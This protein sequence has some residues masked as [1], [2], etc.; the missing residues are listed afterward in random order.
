[1]VHIA[2]ASTQARVSFTGVAVA[3]VVVLTWAASL[4][5][6]LLWRPDWTQPITWL[7]AGLWLLGQTHLYTGLF[8]TAHDAMHGTLAP[9][10]PRLNH[11][12]GAVCATLFAF[13]SYRRL[14]PRHH[15]H[16]RHVATDHDPDYHAPGHTDAFWPWY[17]RFLRE[18]VSWPQ[19]LLMAVTFNVL[20]R[21]LLPLENVLL[22]WMT[23]AVL[24]TLQLFY[25]GTWRPH[26]GV[27]APTNAHRA[28]SQRKNHVWA[29]ASCYFFG[30]HYEHHAHPGVPWWLLWQKKT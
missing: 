9:G 3:A 18:Y 21:W 22:F 1:M 15:D 29:F 25:F 19:L 17:I 6:A 2:A 12:L 28:R 13:N 24:S 20:Y 7:L 27:H 14:L 8:I 26:R 30:Y 11:T 23:P 16:H 10:W 4:V 5:L